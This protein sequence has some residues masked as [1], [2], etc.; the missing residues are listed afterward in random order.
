MA[1][2]IGQIMQQQ[3]A[4][5]PAQSPTPQGPGVGRLATPAPFTPNPNVSPEEKENIA[6]GWREV[7]KKPEAQAA[8][9]QFG[10]SMLNPVTPGGGFMQN[11]GAAI[12]DAG[13]AVN[14][15]QTQ[16]R[17][18][19]AAAAEGSRKA[20][21]AQ[22]DRMGVEQKAEQAKLEAETTLKSKAAEIRA[23]ILQK[24]MELDNKT[25]T[26]ILNAKAKEA[27]IVAQNAALI[28][29]TVDFDNLVDMDA[30]LRDYQAKLADDKVR[31]ATE[32]GQYVPSTVSNLKL[33]IQSYGNRPQELATLLRHYDPEVV[34]KAR[35]ELSAEGGGQ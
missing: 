1:T 11:V 9:L 17:E 31:A 29:Q 34:A 32:A 23:A 12:G 19:A 4:T 20:F 2:N 28:G 3:G 24:G 10:I 35:K 15:L 8:L 22:T 16:D 33:L 18:A 30:V 21:E 27:G 25:F 26:S 13:G 6:N 7:L 14:R 5:A